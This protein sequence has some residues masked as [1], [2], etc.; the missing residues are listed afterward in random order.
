MCCFRVLHERVQ[1][2]LKRRRN[3]KDPFR[4]VN[5]YSWDY[6]IA[7]KVYDETD[8]VSELQ[9]KYNMKYVLDK[10]STG[11]LEIRLFYS[12]QVSFS[13]DCYIQQ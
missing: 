12:L 7:F 5:G 2:A 13:V 1:I 6:M 8:P 11:G 9:C 3:T 4:Q 10:L